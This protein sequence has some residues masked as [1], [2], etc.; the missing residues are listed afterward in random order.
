[1]LSI[2]H[3]RTMEDFKDMNLVSQP[4][5][6]TPAVFHPKEELIQETRSSGHPSICMVKVKGISCTNM[7]EAVALILSTPG[8]PQN[9]P[10][11]L[12]WMHV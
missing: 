10:C 4:G 11:S 9:T 1:M 3:V 5:Q 2:F 7:P 6:T 12:Y 8:N